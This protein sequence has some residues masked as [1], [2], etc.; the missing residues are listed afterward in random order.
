MNISKTGYVDIK[1]GQFAL[2]FKQ[3]FGPYD[4]SLQEHMELFTSRGGGWDTFR[5]SELF[6]IHIV[7]SVAPNT[8]KGHL[9]DADTLETTLPRR[10]PRSHVV[11]GTDTILDAS[12]IRD[13]LF[14]I[15]EL[16]DARIS[17]ETHRLIKEFEKKE[18]AFA[19]THIHELLPHI[20]G[21]TA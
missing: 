13:Q 9:A 14:S 3:P 17:K 2:V 8:Y 15:G 20:F 11:A 19:L 1:P 18:R 12:I 16:A 21:E 6:E 10:Y 4:R 5:A 7:C